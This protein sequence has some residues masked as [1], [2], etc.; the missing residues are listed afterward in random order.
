MNRID[1]RVVARWGTNGARLVCSLTAMAFGPAFWI[2]SAG[3]PMRGQR[4]LTGMAGAGTSA[5]LE[6]VWVT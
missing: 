3:W 1:R 5:L 4:A 2:T 6:K